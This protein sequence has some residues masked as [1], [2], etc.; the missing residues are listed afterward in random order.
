[1]W[2]YIPK[3]LSQLKIGLACDSCHQNL[4]FFEPRCVQLILRATFLRLVP[5]TVISGEE[6]V[7]ISFQWAPQS[8]TPKCAALI[9]L[10]N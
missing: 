3:T 2:H 9:V 10:L 8:L 6:I 5:T 7:N 4:R 1:M